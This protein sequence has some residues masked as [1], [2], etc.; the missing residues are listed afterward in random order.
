MG[1]LRVQVRRV[2]E[3]LGLVGVGLVLALTV[4]VAGQDLVRQAAVP[5]I[6]N[7]TDRVQGTGVIIGPRTVL[8]VRHVVASQLTI[9]LADGSM[10][11]GSPVCIESV[12]IGIIIA[13]EYFSNDI[14]IYPVS[15]RTPHVGDPVTIP[16]YPHGVWTVKT[17]RI[18][19]MTS[20][21]IGIATSISPGNS[22]SPV[23]DATGSVVGIATRAT[24]DLAVAAATTSIASCVR[25][26]HLPSQ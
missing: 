8:S 14:Q 16:G 5:M 25:F 10:I 13:G 6:L 26:L 18:K 12:D 17:G 11:P 23:I 2:R 7:L 4:P 21:L 15:L 24:Q 19:W 22:G 1:G 9:R 3:K 20:D